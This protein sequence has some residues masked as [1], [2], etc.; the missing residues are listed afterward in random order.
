VDPKARLYLGLIL[1]IGLGVPG[2]LGLFSILTRHHGETP[3]GHSAPP[4]T[5]SATST[6]TAP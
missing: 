4:L 5:N 3:S 2:L 6:P 1:T